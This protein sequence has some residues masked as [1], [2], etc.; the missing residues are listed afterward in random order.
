MSIHL[1]SLFLSLQFWF[2]HHLFLSTLLSL[3]LSSSLVVLV[4]L[5]MLLFYKLYSL[6]R[7]AHT[8]E[9]WQSFSLSD[10]PLPQSAG[11][12]AQVLQLQ[13]QFHQAQLGKWQ[14]I[15]QSSV[16][17]LDQMKQ[18]LEKLHRGIVTPEVQQDPPSNPTS[19][20]LTEH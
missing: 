8:L 15:L 13:R 9:T 5:N 20:S 14:Q 2:S 17:L 10:S 7:A 16:T 19:E 4:A 18:S 3:F 6:E 12:W 11:E 1:P